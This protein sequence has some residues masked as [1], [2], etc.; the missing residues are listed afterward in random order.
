MLVVVAGFAAAYLFVGPPPPKSFRLAAGAK[1]GAYCAFAQ[2]YAEFLSQRGVRMDIVETAGT[3]ENL[4]LLRDPNSGVD[5]ALVQGGVVDSASATGLVGLGSVCLEP[6]WVFLRPGVSA[7]YLSDLKARRIAVG[8]EGSGT[9]PLALKLLAANGVD[10]RSA[11]LLPLG[12]TNA[13]NA[14]LAGRADALMTVASVDAGLVRRLLE[15]TNAAPFSLVRADAYAHR[16]RFLSAVRLPQGVID[17]ELNRPPADLVVVSPAATLVARES[18]HPALAD[19]MLQAA[20]KVH[21]QGDLVSSPG[22]FPSPLYLD[23]PLS[24][25]AQRYFKYGPPFLQR[26]LPFWVA[27]TIDRIKVMAL[28]LLV[29]LLPL[30]KIVPPTFRWR[31]R[32]K[33][34]RWYRQL[35][36]L[37]ARVE[38]A[39]GATLL[40]LRGEIDQVEREVLRI[41]V[42]LGFADQLYNLRAHIALVRARIVSRQSPSAADSVKAIESGVPE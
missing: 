23:M 27:T 40:R 26:F 31:I 24:R 37:D 11:S 12:G 35:Y 17:L 22:Q 8:A 41:M 6:L 4:R 7:S 33:I 1:G 5:V 28:P 42:P 2:R 15:D 20:A 32:G 16:F 14:L 13:V 25:D 10:E 9:R 3:V 39:D 21:A 38:G 29:L 36:A 30:F 19:L 34:T 18:F